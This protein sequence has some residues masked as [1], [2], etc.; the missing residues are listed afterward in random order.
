MPKVEFV[1][2]DRIFAVSFK[3]YLSTGK[4][5]IYSA[6]QSCLEALFSLGSS[7]A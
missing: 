7:A 6:P 5:S 4:S 3:V 2:D 1:N